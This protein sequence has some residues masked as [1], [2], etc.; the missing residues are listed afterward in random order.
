MYLYKK[1]FICIILLILIFYLYSQYNFNENF[2]TSAESISNISSMFNNGSIIANKI[3]VTNALDI[4]GNI[5]GKNLDV[6]GDIRGKNLNI[7]GDITGNIRAKY[8]N[9]IDASGIIFGSDVSGIIFPIMYRKNMVAGYFKVKA[10]GYRVPLYYGWNL[11][12]QN[13]DSD[14][15][16]SRLMVYETTNG[17]SINNVSYANIDTRQYV[18]KN[19][20]PRGLV[21][22]PGYYARLMYWDINSTNIDIFSSGVYDWITLL[23]QNFVHLIHITF[24]EEGPSTHTFQCQNMANYAD[25]NDVSLSKYPTKMPGSNTDFR[26]TTV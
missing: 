14:L 20:S 3:L 11:L 17:R 12:W 24:Q 22:F 6:S 9:S 15:L 26:E 13:G 10:F 25:N 18:D 21:L 5:T 16:A 2:I 23:N 1:L 8:I 7:S 19:W 4:S